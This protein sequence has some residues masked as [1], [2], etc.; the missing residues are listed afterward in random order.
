MRD[1]TV[2]APADA[3]PTT[4]LAAAVPD[5]LAD[6][7]CPAPFQLDASQEPATDVDEVWDFHF[8]AD[9]PEW[10]PLEL[11][12]AVAPTLTA[13]SGASARH[14]DLRLVAI[15]TAGF[16]DD[17]SVLFIAARP[18]RQAGDDSQRY[19]L[20]AVTKTSHLAR[21]LQRAAIRAQVD[22]A[23]CRPAHTD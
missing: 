5:L 11:P 19:A 7:A 10:E 8:D 20:T 17:A 22:H 1:D 3:A 12:S 18:C 9:A 21:A 13:L 4:G 14:G 23:A 6:S 16:G 2:P 15:H